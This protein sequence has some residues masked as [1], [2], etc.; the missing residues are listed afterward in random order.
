MM[1]VMRHSSH[2][3][4]PNV[5]GATAATT[6]TTTTDA[7][8]L[9]GWSTPSFRPKRKKVKEFVASAMTAS[10]RIFKFRP[11]MIRKTA[12]A[13]AAS[14]HKNRNLAEFLTADCPTDVLPKI[15]AYAGPNAA[16]A[17]QQTSRHF[18]QVLN[19]EGTWRGLCEELYKVCCCFLLLAHCNSRARK[20]HELLVYVLMVLLLGTVEA[21]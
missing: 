10:P 7:S 19:A 18:F 15:L 6:T 3:V 17:L 16:A 11:P 14:L 2:R 9:Q 13:A 4:V 1:M 21:G 8:S 12:A 20:I 5:P